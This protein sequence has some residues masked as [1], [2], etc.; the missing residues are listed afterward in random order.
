M[1]QEGQ[2]YAAEA[3]QDRIDGIARQHRKWSS[4]ELVQQVRALRGFAASYEFSVVAG[5]ADALD[6]ELRHHRQHALVALY[7]DRMRDALDADCAPT[8]DVL[9]L[10]LASIQTRL[11]VA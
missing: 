9:T 4:R 6:S 5:L 1:D 2:R 3:I 10:L 7:L 11:A 8:S